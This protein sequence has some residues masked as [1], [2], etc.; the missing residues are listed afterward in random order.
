MPCASVSAKRTRTSVEKLNPCTRRD[1]CRTH[2]RES[3]VRRADRRRRLDRERHPRLPQ[4]RRIWA[5][6]DPY[7]VASIDGFRR[8]PARVWEFYGRRLGVLARRGAER[9]P[10][11][12]RGARA[13]GLVQAVVTQNVDRLHAR[14]GSRDVIEVHGSIATR[15]LPRAAAA[16]RQRR[17]ASCLAAA[18]L[19]RLR[20]R[21]QA[22]RGDVRRAAAGRRRSI[23]RRRSPR[24]RRCC[25]SSAP[26]WRCGRSPGCPGRHCARR[27]SRS[28]TASRRRTTRRAS[29]SCVARR[30]MGAA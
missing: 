29:S 18:A 14:A 22:R 15:E 11:C 3:A 28:S 17:C 9:R 7:E 2:P 16:A 23:A 19:R 26:R 8:D 4:R 20:R 13:R 25:S 24:R 10:P 12:A 6:Y 30:A 5:R 1:A 21:A 27:R